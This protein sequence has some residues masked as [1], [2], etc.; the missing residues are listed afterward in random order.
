MDQ[1]KYGVEISAPPLGAPGAAGPYEAARAASA[2][3]QHQAPY[4]VTQHALPQDQPEPAQDGGPQAPNRAYNQ[5]G[6]NRT[7]ITAE[8][9][10]ESDAALQKKLAYQEELR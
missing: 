7:D 1:M 8:R 2:N 10:Q 3:H 9:N 5:G 4:P 6:R